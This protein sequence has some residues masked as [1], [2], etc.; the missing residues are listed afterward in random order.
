MGDEQEL[1]F[2]FKED[3]VFGMGKVI[4]KEIIPALAIIGVLGYGCFHLGEK[5]RATIR[6]EMEQNYEIFQN[7]LEGNLDVALIR[8]ESGI[9][10]GIGDYGETTIYD[11]KIPHYFKLPQ[12]TEGERLYAYFLKNP[13]GFVD[14]IPDRIDY[15]ALT[16]LNPLN[17]LE[18]KDISSIFNRTSGKRFPE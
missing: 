7:V 6:Q 18:R 16:P 5:H 17:R 14:N 3:V 11:L 13:D 9:R 10:M 1:K 2:S 15:S 4:L 8:D 12:A